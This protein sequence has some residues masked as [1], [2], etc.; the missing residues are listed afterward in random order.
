MS[1]IIDPIAGKVYGL[2]E[3]PNNRPLE[4]SQLLDFRRTS[5]LVIVDPPCPEN[6]TPASLSGDLE[7]LWLLPYGE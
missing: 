6:Y 5:R 2:A 7:S 3:P 1:L 4:S